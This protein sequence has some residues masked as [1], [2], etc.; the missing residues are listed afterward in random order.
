VIT[1]TSNDD[2]A[3]PTNASYTLAR[4]AESLQ[5]AFAKLTTSATTLTCRGNFQ[6]PGAWKR[7][8]NPLVPVGTV[9]CATRDSR[10]LVA[11]TD[12]NALFLATIEATLG[13]PALPQLYDWWGSHS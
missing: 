1:C 13:G 5:A 3:G 9:Y 4:S 6:S 10:P 2:L 12:D 11:W 7:L 8:S